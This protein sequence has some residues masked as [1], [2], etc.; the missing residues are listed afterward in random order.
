MPGSALG[1]LAVGEER[2]LHTHFAVRED[3]MQLYGFLSEDDLQ[4]FRLL[5]GVSGVGPKGALGILSQMNGDDLRFA[6]LSDDAQSIAKAQGIGKKT[7]QKVILELKDK[8]DLT[9]LP[10]LRS[11]DVSKTGMTV[12][13]VT[14]NRRLNYL[15]ANNN[16][17]KEI[18][19][20]NNASLDYIYLQNNR[21]TTFKVKKNMPDLFKLDLS[22]NKLQKLNISPLQN[23]YQ[24][25]NLENNPLKTLTVSKKVY[26]GKKWKVEK[27][28]LPDGVKIRAK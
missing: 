27:V 28:V 4:V 7:A 24:L 9:G 17:L 15:T 6:V 26:D 25:L 5:L 19:L 18:D 11:L 16:R 13:D 3:A 22:G 14:K 12:L 8:L 20:S 10:Y 23:I 1:E 2:K 21:L